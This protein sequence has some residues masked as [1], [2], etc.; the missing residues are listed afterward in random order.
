MET[1]GAAMA[2]GNAPADRCCFAAP[3][4][5]L[6]RGKS[7][8]GKIDDGKPLRLVRA[9][10]KRRRCGT[11]LLRQTARLG[12]AELPGGRGPWDIPDV[13][14]LALVVDLQGA[15]LALIQGASDRPSAAF[16]QRAPGHGNW[17]E[18]RT[19]DPVAALEFY[20]GRFGWSCGGP[21]DAVGADDPNRAGA[22]VTISLPG[23]KARDAT[24]PPRPRRKI[25][26]HD[27]SRLPI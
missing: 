1:A 5:K 24:T 3:H 2:S 9:G 12:G 18:L 4:A 17:H 6:H 22:L 16:D 8:Q 23:I 27:E 21:K 7:I 13:G 19:T 15:G 26:L 25:S 14:R 10:D 20:A 11:G